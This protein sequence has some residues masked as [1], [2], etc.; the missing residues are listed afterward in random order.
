MPFQVRKLELSDVERLTDI[1]YAAFAGDPWGQIM[2]P[3]IPPMSARGPTIRRYRNLI[4]NDL[5]VELMKVVDTDTGEM[6]SFARWEMYYHERPESEY[7]AEAQ[8]K[9]EWDEGTNTEATDAL[10]AAVQVADEKLIG[11]RPHCRKASFCAW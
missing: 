7:R 2:F 1:Q 5:T 3:K 11:G 10:I 8:P 4:E 9:R 6:V